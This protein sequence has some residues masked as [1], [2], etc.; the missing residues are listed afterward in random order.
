MYPRRVLAQ[1]SFNSKNSSW[2]Q[3]ANASRPLTKTEYKYAER[4]M[5]GLALSHGYKKNFLFMG[6]HC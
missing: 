4:M 6:H 5:E 3:V 1:Y 2:R